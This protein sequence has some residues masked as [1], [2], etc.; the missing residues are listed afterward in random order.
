MSNK[1]FSPQVRKIASILPNQIW[2]RNNIFEF[3]SKTYIVEIPQQSI[4][5]G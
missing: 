4:K 5:G 1:G 3:M 2:V